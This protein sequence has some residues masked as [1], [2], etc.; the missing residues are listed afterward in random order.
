MQADG[1]HDDG[2]FFFLCKRHRNTL[3]HFE[4]RFGLTIQATTFEVMDDEHEKTLFSTSDLSELTSWL[5]AS[6]DSR[7]ELY[8]QDSRAQRFMFCHRPGN[9]HVV[10][11]PYDFL[12]EAELLQLL[13]R[14]GAIL[15]W[16]WHDDAPFDDLRDMRRAANAAHS[17]FRRYRKGQLI[18]AD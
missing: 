14:F 5:D 16:G 18:P 17:V 3:P 6:P 15:G 10:G 9:H 11:I 4:D 12:N 8:L 7:F 1:F 13:K 2:Y